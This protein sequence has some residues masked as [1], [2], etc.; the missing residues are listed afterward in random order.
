M[1]TD[2]K[3][4]LIVDDEKSV[5]EITKIRLEKLGYD[6]EC[7]QNGKEALEILERKEFSLIL[8]DLR[9]ADL[10]GPELCLRIKERNPETVIY[11]FSGHV[12]EDDFDQLEEMGF[13]GLLCKP[14]TSEILEQSVKG[15][16][17][18]MNNRRKNNATSLCGF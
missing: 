9:L 5:R 17:E 16:F 4:I 6:P 2:S 12:T 8:M 14:V 11:A 15:A 18:Q 10:E 1:I 3:K 13:D 7:A